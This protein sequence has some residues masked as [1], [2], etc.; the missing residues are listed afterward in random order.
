MSTAERSGEISNE[1]AFALIDHGLNQFIGDSSNGGLHGARVFGVRY[2]GSER[3]DSPS[4]GSIH[5]GDL[6]THREVPSV[7]FD[8][9]CDVIAF[10]REREARGRDSSSRYM[11]RRRWGCRR[12]RC[13]VITGDHHDVVVRAR[14]VWGSATD[15]VE[16]R[17]WVIDDRI[18]QKKKSS[19]SDSHCS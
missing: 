1:F 10:E 12:W 4:V 13:F 9:V 6:V 17:I 2:T 16:V 3:P 19:C 14:A 15:G 7:N 18:H 11:K 5:C 8:E